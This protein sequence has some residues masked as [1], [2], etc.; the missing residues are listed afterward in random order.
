MMESIGYDSALAS[1]PTPV[2][3]AGLPGLVMASAGLLGWWRRKRKA[4]AAA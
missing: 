1:V 3:R 4:E 2:V